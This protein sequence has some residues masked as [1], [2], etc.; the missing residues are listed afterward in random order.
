MLYRS[1]KLSNDWSRRGSNFL[2]VIHEVAESYVGSFYE[3][4]LVPAMDVREMVRLHEEPDSLYGIEV[5]RIGGKIERLKEMPVEFFA[6][7]PGRVVED[8]NIPLPCRSY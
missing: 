2:R 1:A 5:G 7:M 6:F 8:D 3:R 4:N